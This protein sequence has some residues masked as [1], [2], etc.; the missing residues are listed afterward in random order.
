MRRQALLLVWL[1]LVGCAPALVREPVER[2][3]LPR[4]LEV[5]WAGARAQ[6][7]GPLALQVRCVGEGPVALLRVLRA[8]EG[9]EVVGD[10]FVRGP[11][12]GQ[13]RYDADGDC[14]VAEQ[15]GGTPF[16]LADAFRWYDL[17]LH[18]GGREVTIALGQVEPG[19]TVRVLVEYVPLSY[20][21]L[22]RA[23]YVA[24]EETPATGGGPGEGE[25]GT[26]EVRFGRLSQEEHRRR[27]PRQLFLR[28]GFLPAAV[29]VPLEI[30][31]GSPP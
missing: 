16:S 20:Q 19:S 31:W 5:R 29:K 15:A 13:F 30:P 4:G 6:G 12:P 14:L 8:D 10:E 25:S 1:G 21:R 11:E 24:P 7:K 2:V 9:A 3:S 28:T 26:A 18:P 17:V 23:A 27:R 22:A